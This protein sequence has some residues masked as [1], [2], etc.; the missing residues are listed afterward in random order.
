MI[1]IS[2]YR[3][4]FFAFAFAIEGSPYSC[5]VV[6]LNGVKKGVSGSTITAYGE[7]LQRV[8]L[9]YPARFD[10]NPHIADHGSISVIVKGLLAEIKYIYIYICIL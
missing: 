1:I 2:Y 9:G 4:V 5:D 8:K 3:F 10:I 7:G 6:D